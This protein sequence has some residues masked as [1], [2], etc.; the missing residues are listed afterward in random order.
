MPKKQPKRGDKNKIELNSKGS[1]SRVSYR[2]AV[3]FVQSLNKII[4]NFGR[5]E[6]EW[7]WK[8]PIEGY[9]NKPLIGPFQDRLTAYWLELKKQA[10]S[11]DTM[12]ISAVLLSQ[13][14]NKLTLFELLEK[15]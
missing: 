13:L 14:E 11:V 10:V 4:L 9:Y 8:G 7:S 3:S 15:M 12:L 5:S 6:I 1:K 2:C